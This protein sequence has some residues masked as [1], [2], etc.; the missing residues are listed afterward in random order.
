MFV[1]IEHQAE[2]D[3]LMVWRALRYQMAVFEAQLRQWLQSHANARGFR[4]HPV[5]PIVFY[6]GTRNWERLTP[7][8]ELVEQGQLIADH[9]P[10]LNPVF[11]NL[12]GTQETVATVS[13]TYALR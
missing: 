6:S 2:P 12:S 8:A 3:E 13:V 10:A 5:L 9:L 7:I 1:L 4:F 11:F